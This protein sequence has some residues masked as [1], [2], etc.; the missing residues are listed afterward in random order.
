MIVHYPTDPAATT[1]LPEGTDLKTLTG[2]AG[3]AWWCCDVA[4]CSAEAKLAEVPVP[5]TCPQ[6]GSEAKGTR[7]C[8]ECGFRH[9]THA[10]PKGW[11][12]SNPDDD[13]LAGAAQ[14][15]A[16]HKSRVPEPVDDAPPPVVEG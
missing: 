7:F 1:A 12:T 4:S 10:V 3:E 8:A 16:K 2:R 9:P 13:A 14:F 11:V 5:D 15:C 6:C